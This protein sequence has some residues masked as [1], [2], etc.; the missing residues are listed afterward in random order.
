MFH[1]FHKTSTA[2]APIMPEPL[3]KIEY[4]NL[5]M[6][7]CLTAQA[8]NNYRAYDWSLNEYYVVKPMNRAAY[9]D[10]CAQRW[11]NYVLSTIGI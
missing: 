2:P 1:L 8:I 4:L 11:N 5:L 10:Y 3:S 7:D 6:S 9:A